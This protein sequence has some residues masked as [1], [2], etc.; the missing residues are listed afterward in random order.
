MSKVNPQGY[1]YGLA[2]EN[3]NPFWD[4][5][6]GGTPASVDIT[7]TAS[8][9]D[10]VGTP[11]VTVTK[12]TTDDATN[13]DFAFTG[14]KGEKGEKGEEGPQG[15][16]GDPG[17]AGAQ[18][19]K[20][21]T[22]ATGPQGP[23]GEPGPAGEQGPKGDTG[24]TGPR[25]PKG[26]PGK[27]GAPGANGKDGVSPIVTSTG[28]TASG[29]SA[30]TITGADGAVITVYNGAKGEKGDPGE[31]GGGAAEGVTDVSSTATSDEFN[32]VLS[33]N[34]TKKTETGETT[35]TTKIYAPA[36]YIKDEDAIGLQSAFTDSSGKTVSE[37]PTGTLGL[38]EEPLFHTTLAIPQ[39]DVASIKCLFVTFMANFVTTPGG[40]G[41]NVSRSCIVDITPI[42]YAPFTLD[43][44]YFPM[45]TTKF[46]THLYIRAW[47]SESNRTVY[48]DI[49][50][51]YPRISGTITGIGPNISNVSIRYAT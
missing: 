20:G 23:K 14:I 11:D 41:H 27:D 46:S 28:S 18:G 29:E 47:F 49:F 16:K 1:K 50:S 44:Y 17:E 38:T 10:T 22:G 39:T 12:H 32:T 51:T 33:I 8:V 48:L 7:A 15:P 40:T 45:F 13:F 30:G 36:F 21:D 2:P 19:P 35:S 42:I 26:D 3:V 43:G 6:N 9:D 37:S 24:A 4:Y 34:A 5:E 25:G 31:A